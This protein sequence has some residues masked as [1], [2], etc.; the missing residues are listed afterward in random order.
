MS[1][2]VPILTYH[3]MQIEGNDYEN[4][5]HVALAEDLRFIHREGFRILPL[6]RIVE[7][8]LRS[9]QQLEGEKVVALTCDD[10][11]DFDAVDLPH[12]VAGN[13]RSMLNILRDFRSANEGAQPGL[14]MTSFVIVSPEAR[15]ELD[16]TCMIG[17]GWWNETWWRDAA[18]SGLMAIANHSWD[19]NHPSV[20]A[21]EFA[22]I[23]RGTFKSVN[24]DRLA[25]YQIAQASE[26]LWRTAPNA[27]AA[28]FGYPYGEVNDFL[29]KDYL[30]RRGESL[31][32]IAAFADGAVPMTAGADRWNIP[33]FVFRRD[34][35]S[36]ADLRSILKD[37][38]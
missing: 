9:P 21:G 29:V 31:G 18:A 37:A 1:L 8:W 26:Y 13:Q 27:G 17:L 32:L 12:P 15:V 22:N 4:N 14:S 19:H 16:K 11:G 28:L 2:K 35:K 30:P 33:R 20:P 23:E 3:S 7:I 10:G 25:D 5:D 24:S 34:W 36:H 38:R 6:A